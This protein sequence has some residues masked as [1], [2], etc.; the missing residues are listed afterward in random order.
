M[1][2][3]QLI[4]LFV[5]FSAMINAQP[6]TYQFLVGTYTKNSSAKGIYSIQFDGSL[7]P[8]ITLLAEL[9]DPNF[10]CFSPDNQFLYSLTAKANDT[11]VSA[12]KI[13]QDKLVFINKVDFGFNPGSCHVSA[14]NNH[15]V[16]ANYGEGSVYVLGRTSDGALT[17]VVQKIQHVGSSVNAKRQEK[18]HAHQA[19]FSP[20]F[21]YVLVSD[22]GVDKVFVYKYDATNL[23][24]PL[25]LSQ[26]FSVK[27]GSGPRHL[28]FDK[29]GKF[30]FLLHELDGSVSV[31][32]FKNGQLKLVS[33]S[34]VVLKND[35]Q[36]G[37]ADIH[38]SA[39]GQFL[40]ATNR[41]T[42]ND[43]TCFKV[44]KNGT[45]SFVQ[46]ISVEGN[47]PRNF[48][49]SRDGKFVLIGNQWTHAVTF[50]RR[51]VKTGM[52]TF[53]ELKVDL[54]SPVCFLEY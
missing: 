44:A 12:F 25:S 7:V 35:I 46:Q 17:S 31:L 39:D 40:Y 30:A 43:I 24:S 34:T 53:G 6:K 18:A 33:T 23:S 41:G 8:K 26:E 16:V 22:L 4:S 48:A 5:F 1:K 19:V 38:L 54:G 20:D 45:L 42:A 21:K 50:F 27:A 3:L 52:L 2:Q 29:A 15:V 51:N 13:E 32:G 14:S 36:T 47:G 28:T 37:A 9:D 10:L 49:I 11:G